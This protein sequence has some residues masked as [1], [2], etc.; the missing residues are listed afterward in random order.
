MNT[1]KVFV[2]RQPQ[3]GKWIPIIG[4]ETTHLLEHLKLSEESKE[5]LKREAIEILSKCGNPEKQKHKDVG[6]VFGYE[7]SG[8][9]LSF[10][11]LIALAKDNG[12]RL[13]IL[14]AGIATN[15]VEQS[16]TRLE[17]DLRIDSR[18]DMQWLS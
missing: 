9:T 4:S 2:N 17:K 5:Q 10:T 12:Y 1:E 13:I 11:T 7:Q 16:S 15:L 8:K 14:I 18:Q 6:L 3:A